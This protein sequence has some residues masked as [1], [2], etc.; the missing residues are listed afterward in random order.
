[1]NIEQAKKLWNGQKVL[2]GTHTRPGVIV[3]PEEDG[4]YI[5]W[6]DGCGLEYHE[7]DEMENITLLKPTVHG[8]V[9]GNIF[10]VMAAASQAL[11]RAG[12][13]A[14]KMQERVMSSR[15][16]EE[17]LGVCMEYVEFEL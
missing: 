13:D 14:A 9:D 3:N 2:W 1:M 16:Y 17:A 15:S 5:D 10:A 6:G 7:Y 4:L 8:P 12:L 11:K